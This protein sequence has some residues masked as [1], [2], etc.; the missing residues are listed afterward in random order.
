MKMFAINE[1]IV[2]KV[3]KALARYRDVIDENC[4][5]SGCTCDLR[6]RVCSQWISDVLHDFDTGLTALTVSRKK[7]KAIVK[8]LNESVTPKGFTLEEFAIIVANELNIKV[9]D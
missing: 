6:D 7:I 9:E 5:R 3:S 1:K 4:A 8:K 2:K